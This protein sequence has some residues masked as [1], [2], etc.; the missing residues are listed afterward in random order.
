MKDFFYTPSYIRNK[1]NKIEELEAT[2]QRVRELHKQVQGP[3]D[4]YMCEHCYYDEYRFYEY[5]CPTI[6]ALDED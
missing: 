4:N 1:I 6:K 2:L 5:P 3:H